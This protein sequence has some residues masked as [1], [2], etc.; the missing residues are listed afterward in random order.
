MI[1]DR[2]GHISVGLGD[3]AYD[4]LKNWQVADKIVSGLLERS[5]A[6]RSRRPPM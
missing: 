3:Y 5:S 1:I 4:G 2:G 6:A